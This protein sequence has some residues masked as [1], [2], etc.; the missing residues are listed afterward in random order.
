MF[1]KLGFL[2]S[3]SPNV[4]A[5]KKYLTR[6]LHWLFQDKC[7]EG[8]LKFKQAIAS[9]EAFISEQRTKPLF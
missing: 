4:K 5:V 3:P 9:R 6:F 7:Q 2:M 1:Q 8:G